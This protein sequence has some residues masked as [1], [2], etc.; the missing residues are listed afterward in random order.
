MHPPPLVAP[1]E[2]LE[3]DSLPAFTRDGEREREREKGGRTYLKETFFLRVIEAVVNVEGAVG[4]RPR[5]R[6]KWA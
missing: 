1:V 4:A 3:N 6:S 5:F 2:I